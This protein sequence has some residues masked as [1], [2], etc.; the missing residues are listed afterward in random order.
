MNPP[1]GKSVPPSTQPA[2]EL[3]SLAR[4]SP[5]LARQNLRSLL[6]ANPD[7]FGN[8]TDS[9]FKAVLKI[10]EDTTYES[11][12]CISYNPQL[13][14]LRSTIQIRQ[15]TGYSADGG[16]TGSE[17]YVRFYLSYDG[18]STWQDQGLRAV[19]VFDVPGPKPLEFAV[20]LQ[21][22][23]ARESYFDQNLPLARAI[24]SWSSS[25][26]AATPGWTP[27]WG[28]VV[29][30][31][32]QIKSFDILLLKPVLAD[33]EARLPDK[34]GRKINLNQSARAAHAPLSAPDLH[35]MHNGTAVAPHRC[36][37][38]VLAAAAGSFA[39]AA[40]IAAPFSSEASDEPEPI[41]GIQDSGLTSPAEARLYTGSDAVTGGCTA[42]ASNFASLGFTM[43][44]PRAVDGVLPAPRSGGSIE[45]GGTIAD[46]GVACESFTLTTA[47]MDSNSH[48]LPSG[49]W[50]CTNAGSGQTS[51]YNQASAGFSLHSCG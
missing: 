45:P 19:K 8:I 38:G 12:G 4:L 10:Q 18:G 51:N 1:H 50:D 34:I 24:L 44:S 32:I 22:I 46:S 37:S 31:R 40:G 48:S 15:A 14:Q 49:V 11:I 3:I 30:A 33:A 27:V 9:S 6:L 17:E 13:R 36:G 16:S 41:G 25:P 21:I 47:G 43:T 20:T 2:L 39:F 23:P 42:T 35:K 7:Y 5:E 28:N 29:D 26:P